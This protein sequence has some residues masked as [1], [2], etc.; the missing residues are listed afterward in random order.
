MVLEKCHEEK[1]VR[2]GLEQR[3]ILLNNQNSSCEGWHSNRVLN[4]VEEEALY[5]GEFTDRRNREYL[6]PEMSIALVVLRITCR[7]S[8]VVIEM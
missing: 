1:A 3:A 7:G 5:S 8:S 2:M 6:D 4:E